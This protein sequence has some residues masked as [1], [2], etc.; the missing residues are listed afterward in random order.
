MKIYSF[1]GYVTILAGWPTQ[2][3]VWLEWDFSLQ[4]CV[5]F[6]VARAVSSRQCAN[7]RLLQS[8]AQGKPYFPAPCASALADWFSSVS[9]HFCLPN[10]IC[11]SDL[12]PFSPPLY[13]R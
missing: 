13:E 12:M 3:F 7:L 1:A 11:V 2:A 4:G 8:V 9:V 5:R 6:L 10:D